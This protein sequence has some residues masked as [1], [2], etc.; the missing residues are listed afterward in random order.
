MIGLLAADSV[1]GF[2]KVATPLHRRLKHGGGGGSTEPDSVSTSRPSEPRLGAVFSP[3]AGELASYYHA[4]QRPIQPLA[5]LL[6]LADG[7]LS[8][9]HLFGTDADL[10]EPT[11]TRLS[12]S[13]VDF[14]EAEGGRVGP[15]FSIEDNGQEF[16]CSWGRLELNRWQPG[17]VDGPSFDRA[18]L[19]LK[20]QLKPEDVERLNV[21]GLT[22][23]YSYNGRSSLKW[24]QGSYIAP[25]RAQGS[26][27][28]AQP[29]RPGD[30][31]LTAYFSPEVPLSDARRAM[32]LL[33]DLDV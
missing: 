5:P 7:P 32:S 30:T 27:I 29:I 17:M 18:V 22:L 25:D 14:M 16:L 9:A 1:V 13:S 28:L 11:R 8:V 4:A 20:E 3:S 24:I 6:P 2:D 21:G 26:F 19:R 10:A 23:K 15:E 12:G 33:G 31:E